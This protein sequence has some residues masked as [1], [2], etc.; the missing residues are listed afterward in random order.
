[1]DMGIVNAGF[2]TI[3]D[4]IPKDLLQLCEDAIWN[5]DP[6]TTEKLLAY[7]EQHGK[8][9]E[10]KENDVEE[11]RSYPVEKRLEYSLVK[12]ITKHIIEDT[13]EARQQADK[14]PRPLNVIEGP[15][16]AGMSIVGELFGAGKMFLPQVIKSAR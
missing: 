3:Y 1:M 12:G 11:W 9:K 7:A 6:N 2:L 8:S 4:D 16:M 5:R 13:E 15:L 10:E 14:Y